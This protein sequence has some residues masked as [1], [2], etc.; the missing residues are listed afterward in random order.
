MSEF[1][2]F[3]ELAGQSC[4]VVGGGQVAGR[5]ARVLTD[6]GALVTVAAPE[7]GEELKRNP[8]VTILERPFREEDLEKDWALVIAASDDPQVNARVTALCREKR[9]PVNRADE[10]GKGGFLFPA[11]IHRGD[12]TIGISTGGASPAAAGYFRRLIETVLPEKTEKMLSSLRCCREVVS[13]KLPKEKRRSALLAAAKQTLEKG[14]CLTQQE[15]QRLLN[16]VGKGEP[17]TG[18]V[19][20]VG[21]GCGSA[22]LITVRGLRLVQSCDALVYDELIDKALLDA[23]PP[24]AEKI[25]MGKRAGKE[26]ARQEDIIETMISLARQGKTVVRLK[27]GDPYL[28]GRGGEEQLA[29]QAAGIVWDEVPGIPSAI[30]IPAQF[31]IPVTHRNVSRSLHII[32]AHTADTGVLPPDMEKYAQLSGTLVFLMGLGKLEAIANSLMENGKDPATPAA[33]LS[34]GNAKQQCIRGSLETIAQ[35]AKDA[36]APAI[37]LV[38][39]VAGELER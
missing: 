15:Q 5:K 13:K 9:I 35:L 23:A 37:I 18:R 7:I 25:S 14:D 12:L 32:T 8:A 28:F 30:G 10:Q 17:V 21:A 34:G 2:M 38:G 3:V 1:P 26:S 20:L 39:A 19:H 4:L 16:C 6:C 31:G 33:V 22:D 29:L 24:W 11:L 27:G 36:Q